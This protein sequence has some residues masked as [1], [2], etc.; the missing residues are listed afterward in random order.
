MRFSRA[1]FAKILGPT[2]E[3]CAQEGQIVIGNVKVTLRRFLYEDVIC[4]WMY[5]FVGSYKK[6]QI[7]FDGMWSLDKHTC[8][9][10][11]PPSQSALQFRALSR[12]PCENISPEYIN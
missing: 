3:L 2:R 11:S 7:N 9:S 10:H 5:V 12:K 4:M 8:C 1:D 6:P